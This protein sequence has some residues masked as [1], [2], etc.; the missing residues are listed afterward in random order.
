MTK[1]SFLGCYLKCFACYTNVQRRQLS[2]LL[3][4]YRLWGSF[5]GKPS[6]FFCNNSNTA[7][8]VHYFVVMFFLPSASEYLVNLTRFHL[9]NLYRKCMFSV[10]N[11]NSNFAQDLC[12]I[13]SPVMIFRSKF[14]SHSSVICASRSS[15]S[16]K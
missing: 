16:T 8:T 3:D 1:H 14:N 13:S 11:F 15:T 2:I 10:F 9:V 7:Q 6:K 12:N 5:S 4:Q